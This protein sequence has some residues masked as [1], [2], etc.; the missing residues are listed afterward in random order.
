VSER[1]EQGSRSTGISR[2]NGRSLASSGAAACGV[3][4]RRVI[5]P[6]ATAAWGKEGEGRAAV[7]AC[8]ICDGRLRG[9]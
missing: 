9:P 1:A 4:G 5:L 2:S 8:D 7:G 6:V 3:N